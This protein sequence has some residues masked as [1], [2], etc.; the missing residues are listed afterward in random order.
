[1]FGLGVNRL[2]VPSGK[3]NPA[4]TPPPVFSGLAGL[5]ASDE[6]GF[7]YD[8][9]DAS[10]VF[11]D[12]SGTTAAT[13]GGVVGRIEDKSGNGV[14]LTAGA[15]NLRPSWGRSPESGA[16]NFLE[17]SNKLTTSDISDSGDGWVRSQFT[18]TNLTGTATSDDPPVGT[19]TVHKVACS[20]TSVIGIQQTQNYFVDENQVLSVYLKLTGEGSNECKG[21]LVTAGLNCQAFVRLDT[22]TITLSGSSTSNVVSSS[23]TDVGDGW[24]R[25]VMCINQSGGTQPILFYFIDSSNTYYTFYSS[26]PSILIY[27]PQLEKGTSVTYAQET[28]LV[29]SVGSANTAILDATEEGEDDKYFLYFDSTDVL[30]NSGHSIDTA[31]LTLSAAVESHS[32]SGNYY[33]VALDTPTSSAAQSASLAVGMTSEEVRFRVDGSSD[34][35]ILTD[36]GYEA[37]FTKVLTGLHDISDPA[38]SAPSLYVNGSQV[39]S[40]MLDVGG[41]TYSAS[42]PIYLGSSHS[43][44]T[45]LTAFKGRVYQVV[46][47]GAWTSGSDLNSAITEMGD[48]AGLSL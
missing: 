32:D 21:L 25:F 36:T 33:I 8:P 9:S 23:L 1:M 44:A 34:S 16:R 28:G 14:H 38:F 26:T 15:D 2:G 5:F 35:A 6:T 19:G 4:G 13:L 43:S 29:A 41:T 11:S 39:D 7:W 24:Y 10:T 31:A 3:S 48:S 17:N 42:D 18:G 22:E 12:T 37:P 40:E 27:R 20:S 46:G 47:R 30:S 45:G